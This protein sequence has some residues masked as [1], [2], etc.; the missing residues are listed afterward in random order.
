MKV[1]DAPNIRNVA[2]VG[3]GGC[4]KTSLVSAHA[5]RHG[6]GQPARP[7][8]RRH[9]RHRLRPRRDRAQDQPAD[10]AS[11][12]ASGA[13]PSSTCSTP[14]A[15]RTSCPRRARRCAWRTRAIV[16]VDAVAG[17]RGADREGLG[18]RRGATGSRA[19]IVVN[20]M[21]RERA[22]FERTLESLQRAF[23]RARG[24]ARHPARRGEGLRG[25]GRP[26]DRE[27]RRLRRRPERQVP[28][29]RRCR[30]RSRG[31]AH[32]AGARSSSRWWRR[33]TRT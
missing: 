2:V 30:R 7:R 5:L 27:G 28:G 15:T 32:A 10:G 13:R 3:H 24:A 21:D 20:R 6:R 19:L 25:R 12:T 23:G 17:R 11:P 33:A 18:L 9:D 16:V 22:S 26:G 14:R 31:R 8:G 1:Y 4:G 29:G